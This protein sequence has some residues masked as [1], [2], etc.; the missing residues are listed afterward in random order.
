MQFE[1]SPFNLFR[2]DKREFIN[3][4][5]SVCL[6]ALYYPESGDKMPK[7]CKLGCNHAFHQECLEQMLARN[8]ITCPECRNPITSTLKTDKSLELA[9]RDDAFNHGEVDEGLREEFMRTSVEIKD[10]PYHKTV[11]ER[12]REYRK[13]II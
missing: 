3:K 8:H 9:I 6:M 5:C 4:V 10:Y 7:C 1:L 2:T 11:F 12:W 13:K